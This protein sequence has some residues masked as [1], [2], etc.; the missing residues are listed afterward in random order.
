MCC[1]LVGDGCDWKAFRVTDKTWV[2]WW[3]FW[4]LQTFS[5]TVPVLFWMFKN[6]LCYFW[7]TKSDGN[8]QKTKIM[9]FWPLCCESGGRVAKAKLF[10]L[11]IFVP[12][13]RAECSYGTILISVFWR[14]STASHMNT[15]E[16]CTSLCDASLPLNYLYTRSVTFLSGKE[17]VGYSSYENPNYLTCRLSS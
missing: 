6:L 15:S 8:T 14:V 11:K 5:L 3:S 2:N 9:P 12:V 10:C 17:N 4:F 7:F 16:I 13:N 1:V